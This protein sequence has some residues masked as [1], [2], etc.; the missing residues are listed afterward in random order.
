MNGKTMGPS[1]LP[2]ALMVQIARQW[3]VCEIMRSENGY[4]AFFAALSQGIVYQS[5]RL[6]KDIDTALEFIKEHEK[7]F[8]KQA[9]GLSQ[10]ATPGQ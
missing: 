2:P 9:K 4:T 8:I 1:P 5:S 3:K 7:D 6:F 10:L